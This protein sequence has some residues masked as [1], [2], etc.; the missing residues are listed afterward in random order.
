MRYHPGA[1][2]AISKGG[3]VVLVIFLAAL[4]VATYFIGVRPVLRFRSAKHWPLTRCEVVSSGF[5]T[6][7]SGTDTKYTIA[8]VYRYDIAGETFTSSDYDLFS[9]SS[10]GC[11]DDRELA[12]QFSAGTTTECYVNPRNPRE[13]V[14]NRQLPPETAAVVIPLIF[15]AVFSLPFVLQWRQRGPGRAGVPDAQGVAVALSVEELSAAPVSATLAPRESR[16]SKWVALMM[17]VPLYAFVWWFSTRGLSGVAGSMLGP[18][19]TYY[20]IQAVLRVGL[21]VALAWPPMQIALNIASPYVELTLSPAV[22]RY[23]EPAR[24]EWRLRGRKARVASLRFWVEGYDGRDAPKMKSDRPF[25]RQPLL[26]V[27]GGAIQEAGEFQMMIVG[28]QPSWPPPELASWSVRVEVHAARLPKV[29][30][31]YKF[32]LAR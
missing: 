30:T 19:V 20:F 28:P 11:D 5:K 3:Q 31:F 25:H 7:R 17:L 2:T 16:R 26:D 10:A 27:S 8:V 4:A 21:G 6:D 13:A 24:I 32:D 23:G 14:L 18:T 22:V 1:L 12:R 9:G 15:M 29:V